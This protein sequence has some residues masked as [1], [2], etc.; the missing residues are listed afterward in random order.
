M[1]L[2]Y[3]Y[4]ELSRGLLPTDGGLDT[5]ASLGDNRVSARKMRTLHNIVDDRV[6]NVVAKVKGS[7]EQAINARN[8]GNRVDL[9]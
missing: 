3:G 5:P 2:I 9:S 6:T 7:N 8:F 1:R 4:S